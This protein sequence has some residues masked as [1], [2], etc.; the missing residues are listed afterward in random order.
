MTFFIR[1]NDFF[2]PTW[3]RVYVFTWTKSTMPIDT[4]SMSDLIDALTKSRTTPLSLSGRGRSRGGPGSRGGR[5]GST[6]ARG[7]RSPSPS[8]S[9]ASFD[10]P[11]SAPTGRG[12]GCPRGSLGGPGSRGPRT[13]GAVESQHRVTRSSASV[14]KPVRSRGQRTRN[15]WVHVNS[16]G[17]PRRAKWSNICVCVGVRDWI[18]NFVGWKKSL[19]GLVGWNKSYF[20]MSDKISHLSDKISH[21]SDEKSFRPHS[22][23]QLFILIMPFLW[24][25]LY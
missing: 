3:C 24:N 17:R 23:I 13:R 9:S 14:E 6:G 25:I 22:S 2:H 8:S 5:R 19:F 16:T 18:I 11:V 1:Q 21:L 15:R 12:R 20:W 4:P 7:A 10:S